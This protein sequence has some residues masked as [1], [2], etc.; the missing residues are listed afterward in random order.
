MWVGYVTIRGSLPKRLLTAGLA[1][2]GVVDRHSLRLI[3]TVS[4]LKT[5]SSSQS[6]SFAKNVTELPLQM[7]DS[8]VQQRF[9]G[10]RQSKERETEGGRGASLRLTGGSYLSAGKARN[11]PYVLPGKTAPHTQ[12]GAQPTD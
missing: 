3:K 11:D 1:A 8:V 4:Q 12:A 7:L 2:G 6:R 9:A 5:T 10:G